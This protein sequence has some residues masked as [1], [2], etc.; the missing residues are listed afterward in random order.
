MGGARAGRRGCVLTRASASQNGYSPL[1]LAGGH[2]HL[3]VV[4]LLL[5]AGA[6]KNAPA[7]VRK[8]R[9]GKAMLSATNG[10]LR[11]H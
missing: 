4:N 3:Q 10:A 2:D 7:Q 1:H 5:A 9:G 8:G 11:P 6:E